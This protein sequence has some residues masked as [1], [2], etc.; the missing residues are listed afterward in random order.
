M[1]IIFTCKRKSSQ[2]IFREVTRMKRN[3]R[4]V[5]DNDKIIIGHFKASI[6]DATLYVQLVAATPLV[7]TDQKRSSTQY[8][9]GL[10][11]LFSRTF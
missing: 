7:Q 11:T 2:E 8:S 6:P 4:K 10:I 3:K 9:I 5:E 1:C